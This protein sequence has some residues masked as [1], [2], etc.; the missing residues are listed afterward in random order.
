[1]QQLYSNAEL[2][3]TIS[4][5]AEANYQWSRDRSRLPLRK[6][7]VCIDKEKFCANINALTQSREEKSTGN[8]LAYGILCIGKKIV[9]P[10]LAYNSRKKK[11]T[12]SGKQT[13]SENV[14]LHISG[15][16]AL[17]KNKNKL[18]VP[19]AQA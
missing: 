12:T 14:I 9:L 18:L 15:F 1:M 6:E 2:M 17:H 10:K 8:C 16:G 13:G 4:E 3:C 11:C 7:N 5:Q 19:F